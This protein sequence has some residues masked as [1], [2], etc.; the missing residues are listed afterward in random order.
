MEAKL[1][2]LG[3]WDPGLTEQQQERRYA[4][5]VGTEFG[6]AP[7][8]EWPKLRRGLLEFEHMCAWD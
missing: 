1:R 8:D 5:F 6:V 3:V 2:E 7:I 4:A